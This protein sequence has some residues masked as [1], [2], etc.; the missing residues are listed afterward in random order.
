VTGE[1]LVLVDEQDHEVGTGEKMAVHRAGKLH[2]AFSVFVTDPAGR[3][4]LQRRAGAK[5]HS[6]GKWSNTCCGHPRPGE[7]V[8][9]AAHRRLDEEMGFDCPLREEFI[10]IYRA[11]LD[12]DLVEHELDHVFVGSFDGDPIPDPAEV[13]EWRVVSPSGLAEDLGRH[14]ERYTAW[15]KPALNGLMDRKLLKR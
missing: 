8:L 10:F 6:G 7:P 13:S 5:Y 1:L 15:L 12:H 2:R 14:P 9:A 4:L 3:I 11:D